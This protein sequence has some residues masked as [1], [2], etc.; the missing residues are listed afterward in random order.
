LTTLDAR[1][2]QSFQVGS[3]ASRRYCALVEKRDGTF[4]LLYHDGDQPATEAS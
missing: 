1:H 3:L 4:S 2:S